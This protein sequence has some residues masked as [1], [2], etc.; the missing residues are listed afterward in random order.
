MN[1]LIEFRTISNEKCP[2]IT[3]ALHYINLIKFYSFV[4]LVI[5]QYYVLSSLKMDFSLRNWSNRTRNFPRKY[6]KKN[7][8]II[9]WGSECA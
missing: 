1:T 3:F 6:E 7:I 5:A 2:P 8:D 9:S 4:N